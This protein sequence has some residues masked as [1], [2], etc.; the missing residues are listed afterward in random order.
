MPSQLSYSKDFIYEYPSREITKLIINNINA[1]LDIQKYSGTNKLTDEI[2]HIICSSTLRDYENL[3]N[4]KQMNVFQ[5]LGVAYF[6]AS[7]NSSNIDTIQKE[8]L[9]IAYSS[10]LEEQLPDDDTRLIQKY[11]SKIG[12]NLDKNLTLSIAP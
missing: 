6:L 12:V 10:A 11:A 8:S 1:V 9:Q 5:V 2:N 7:K 4:G 3:N